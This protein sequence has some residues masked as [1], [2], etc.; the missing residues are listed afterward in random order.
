MKDSGGVSTSW[1]SCTG[2][3][4]TCACGE[5]GFAQGDMQTLVFTTSSVRY[6]NISLTCW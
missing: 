3:Q 6:N 4:A 1:S 2:T 5:S